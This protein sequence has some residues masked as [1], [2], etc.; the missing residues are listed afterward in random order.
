VQRKKERREGERKKELK[1]G[2]RERKKG[3]REKEII[4]QRKRRARA[5]LRVR[6][7]VCV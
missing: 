3:E 2:R 5:C 4:K 6:E 1:K 7:S